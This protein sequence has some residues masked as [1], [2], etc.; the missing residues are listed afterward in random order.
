MET[1]GGE[2]NSKNRQ[3]NRVYSIPSLCVN[4][5]LRGAS[6]V[7]LRFTAVALGRLR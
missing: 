6:G 2:M 3:V 4:L 7:E 1:K 5:N